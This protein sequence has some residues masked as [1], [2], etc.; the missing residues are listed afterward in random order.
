M[1]HSSSSIPTSAQ[2]NAHCFVKFGIWYTGRSSVK[3]IPH[4]SIRSSFSFRL[5]SVS[6]SMARGSGGGRSRLSFKSCCATA[7]TLATRGLSGGSIFLRFL[8]PVQFVCFLG[9]PP[10]VCLFRW[11]QNQ[12]PIERWCAL[13][14]ALSHECS[15][16][17]SCIPLLTMP[18]EAVLDAVHT[19]GR[20]RWSDMSLLRQRFGFGASPAGPIRVTQTCLAHPPVRDPTGPLRPFALR[21][22]LPSESHAGCALP[23]YDARP[24]CD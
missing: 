8:I 4:S 24:L 10:V 21:A 15:A 16:H 12:W 23:L 13:L 2:I 9:L 14:E 6:G 19:F 5:Y 3:S 20:G 1:S 22:A 18:V 17:A 7:A 11:T